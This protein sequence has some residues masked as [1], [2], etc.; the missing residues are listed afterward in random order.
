MTALYITADRIGAATGGGIVTRHERRALGDLVG[1]FGTVNPDNRKPPFEQDREALER[2]KQFADV[3]LAH[4]YS[5]CLSDTVK[6]LKDRGARVVYTVAAHSVAVSREEHERFGIPYA[7]LY[8]H[9]CEPAL[10]RRYSAGYFASDVIVCPSTYSKRIVEAQAAEL[11]VPCPRVEIIPHGCDMPHGGYAPEAVAAPPTLYTLGYMGAYGPDKGVIYL[12]KAWKKLAYRD[13]VLVLAGRDSAADW[14]KDMVRQF[15]GGNVAFAGWVNRV[16]DFYNG[17]THYVQP[18][19]CLLPGSLVFTDSGVVPIEQLVSSDRVLTSSGVCENVITPISRKYSGELVVVRS[20]GMGITS[21]MTPEHR[22]FVIRRGLDRRKA[23]FAE[24]QRVWSEVI[25]LRKEY[26]WGSARISAAVG[27]VPASTIECWFRGTKPHTG[28]YG[29]LR[30]V[31]SDVLQNEPEWVMAGDLEVG[32]VVLFPR[33]KTETPISHI[34]LPQK[35][36]GVHGN[37]TKNLPAVVDLDDQTLAF[38]GFYVSEGCASGG[39]VVFCFHSNETDYITAIDT[40]IKSKLGLHTR[41]VSSVDRKSTTVRVESKLLFEF[42]VDNFGRGAHNKRIPLWIMDLPKSQLVS[43]VRG[44]WLGD[45]SKWSLLAGGRSTTYSTVSQTLAMQLFVCITKLGHMPKLN[46][47]KKRGEYAVTVSGND[48][49][50]FARSVLGMELSTKR[51][52]TGQRTYIDADF[53]YMPILSLSRIGYSGPVY[54]LEVAND[55]CYCAPFIVHNSE[56]FGIEV[57]EAM[58]HGREVLCSDG[59]GAADVVR[60]Y[61]PPG[62]VFPARD[63]DALAD[64]IDLARREFEEVDEYGEE[65]RQRYRKSVREACQDVADEHAWERIR[66]RYVAL[67]RSLLVL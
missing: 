29:A 48:G 62:T 13:A 56:G 1:A 19:A 25:R 42:M 11:G 34:K 38:F 4:C 27:G 16:A 40:F 8:P 30:S 61:D 41:T 2:V 44:A 22:V 65:G 47:F 20:L 55:H 5:G 9:L 24:K 67:W 59:A 15:G 36:Q 33:P 57:L 63:A 7:R 18:S 23:M 14:M 54:N 53:Y 58:A 6:Y 50:D 28:K 60:D 66:R 45:G 32:D 49:L 21:A 37:A 46:F 31:R 10:W 26:G 3:T 17:I 39:A 35:V 52:V 64:A 43:F 51:G 12:L